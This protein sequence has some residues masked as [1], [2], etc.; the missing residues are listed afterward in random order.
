MPRCVPSTSTP[1]AARCDLLR[2]APPASRPPRG[3]PHAAGAGAGEGGRV[4]TAWLVLP[5]TPHSLPPF[6]P[7]PHLPPSHPLFPATIHPPSFRPSPQPFLTPRVHTLPSASSQVPFN[8]RPSRLYLR[9][10]SLSSY[11]HL[12]SASARLGLHITFHVLLRGVPPSTLFSPTL[13][14]FSSPSPPL[15]PPRLLPV[16]TAYSSPSPPRLLPVSSPSPP[17]LLPVSPSH[18]DPPLPVTPASTS[19]TKAG[20]SGR[21]SEEKAAPSAQQH[22]HGTRKASG[23]PPPR[24]PDGAGAAGGSDS[25]GKCTGESMCIGL[26]GGSGQ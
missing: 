7:F 13:L 1:R 18:P 12:T 5:L 24:V 19:S 14:L 16:S 11:M 8:L 20:H 9:T 6:P 22:S 4:V 17:R 25:R 10:V 23:R 15:T 21:P 3:A 2:A 26:S